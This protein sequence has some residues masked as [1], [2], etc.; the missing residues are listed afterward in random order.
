MCVRLRRFNP[1]PSIKTG[2]TY[3]QFELAWT[4][5][6]SIHAHQLRRAKPQEIIGRVGVSVFQSTPIN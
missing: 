5:L 3:G 4:N 6:V 2:E 1:R